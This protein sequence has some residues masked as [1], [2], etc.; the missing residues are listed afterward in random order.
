MLC[1]S[2]F[3]FAL[4]LFV[5]TSGSRIV[6]YHNFNRFVDKPPAGR[7]KQDEHLSYQENRTDS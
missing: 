5:E 2:I 7:V 4:I 6:T 3:N 1:C